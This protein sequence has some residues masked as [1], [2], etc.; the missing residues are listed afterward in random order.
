M[1]SIEIGL[2]V[3]LGLI[4]L[5]LTWSGKVYNRLV[6]LK[7]LNEEGWSGI[8]AALQ[9][10]WDLIPS[11]VEVAERYMTHE[12]EV[13]QKI[14]EARSCGKAAQSVSEV[15]ESEQ[16]MRSAM[17][18]FNIVMEN[19]P[20]LK[21]DESMRNIQKEMS[22]MEE[23]LERNRRYYNATSR[24]FNMKLQQF[25]AN[26][27]ADFFRFK[28]VHYFELTTTDAQNRPTTKFS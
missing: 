25:P 10:R 21:A 7:S 27:I 22:A 17:A 23:N 15:V 1:S 20:Q 8:M 19:Y 4:V 3:A 13:F 2:L 12:S 24:D 16:H 28:K 5:F 11:I 6:K 14:S 26:L 9:R 18:A